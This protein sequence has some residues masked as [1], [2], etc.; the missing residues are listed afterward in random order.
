[1]NTIFSICILYNIMADEL[2]FMIHFIIYEMKMLYVKILVAKIDLIL[3][4]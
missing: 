1:M 4:L 2:C 3:L